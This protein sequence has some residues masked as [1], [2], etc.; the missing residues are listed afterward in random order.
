MRLQEIVLL[1]HH[2]APARSDSVEF[3]GA[4]V[5]F[6]VVDHPLHREIPF[7]ID[8]VDRV[9]AKLLGQL[10]S[11]LIRLVT[12]QRV[13]SREVVGILLLHP[14]APDVGFNRNLSRMKPLQNFDQLRDFLLAFRR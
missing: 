8:G 5:G 1:L 4:A 6:R 2:C 7:L 11:D 12:R 14:L 13:L 3:L 10:V 9:M